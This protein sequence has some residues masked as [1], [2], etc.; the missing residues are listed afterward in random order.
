MEGYHLRSRSVPPDTRA[1]DKVFPPQSSESYHTP[2]WPVEGSVPVGQCLVSAGRPGASQE[3]Q[4]SSSRSGTA[5]RVLLTEPP[6]EICDVHALE[7]PGEA[8]E[9]EAHA[10]GG[11]SSSLPTWQ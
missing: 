2:E 7:D 11:A 1:P 10:N 6:Q 5:L 3:H 4:A 9:A 8:P